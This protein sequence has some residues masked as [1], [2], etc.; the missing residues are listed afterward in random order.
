[1]RIACLVLALCSFACSGLLAQQS[2][3]ADASQQRATSLSAKNLTVTGCVSGGQRRFT[4]SQQGTGA[5]FELQANREELRPAVGKMVEVTAA[6][7]APSG[8]RGVNA[9]PSLKVSQMHVVADKCPEQKTMPANTARTGRNTSTPSAAA[10]PEF[11]APGADDQ[12]P[13][14]VGNNP[15]TWGNGA[16]GAPSPGTGNP[17]SSSTTPP[18]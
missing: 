7:K 1:M 11:S 10:T 17:P 6:E 12:T 18:K 5:M 15:T 8:N 14:A 4:L 2:S 9:L 16:H 13:P 3:N